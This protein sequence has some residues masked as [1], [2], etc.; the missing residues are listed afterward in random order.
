MTNP[1]RPVRRASEA[2]VTNKVQLSPEMIR[3]SLN[4][5]GLKGQKLAHTDHYIKF[6]FVPEEADYSWPFDLADIRATR[7]R[8]LHPVTRT[9]TLR[10]VDVES[11]DMDIDF[12]VH[13]TTGLASSWASRA[14]IGDVIAFVGPGGAWHP[15]KIYSHFVFVGDETAAPAI[16]AGVEKLPPGAT[17][18]VYV[19]ISGA[20]AEFEMPHG[21][22]V[23]MR[24]IYRDNA[25]HGTALAQAVRDAGIPD[26]PT[27][28]FIHGV[29]EMVKEMRRFLFIENEVEKKDV[30][31]SGYWRLGMTEDD[32]Q[33]SKREFVAEMELLEAREGL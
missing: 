9:Y 31:I 20:G 25:L 30:S 3:L 13:S 12:V 32:W 7:P 33:A 8:H 23:N 15:E 11:G 1:S 4:A 27:G 24:W 29:A 2:R 21:E 26:K 18:D 10:R 16:A 14:E 19:E 6:L 22:G 17:A 5:P 28:W